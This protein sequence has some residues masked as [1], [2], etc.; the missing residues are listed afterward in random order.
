MHYFNFALCESG[1]HRFNRDTY[2]CV[3]DLYEMDVICV[4]MNANNFLC[5]AGEKAEMSLEVY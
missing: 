1:S 5:M 3:F 2:A 4:S